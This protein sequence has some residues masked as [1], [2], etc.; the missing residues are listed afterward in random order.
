MLTI[1]VPRREYFD[2]E[3][4]EFFYSP[5]TTLS[6]EHSLVSISKWESKWHKSFLSSDDITNEQMMD[7]IKCMTISKNTDPLVYKSLTNDNFRQINEY[8]GNVMTATTFAKENG[9]R[10]PK[11]II[12]SELI[13]YWMIVNNIPFECD[14]WHIN[15]LLTLIKVCNI[16]NS[17]PKKRSKAEILASNKKLNDERR[18]MFE[19]G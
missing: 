17:P 5:Q 16:K 7:Y 12:T 6:L 11:E 2:D 4:Q 9:Q 19:E 8:V 1:T 15:R 18:K 10:G 13:Y 14:K 3:R